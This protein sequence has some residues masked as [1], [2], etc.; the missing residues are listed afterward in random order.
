MPRISAPTLVEHRQRQRAAL[1]DA[2]EDIVVE[3]GSTNVTVSAVA[4]RAGLARSS[5]YEYF[6]SP[7]ALLAA[8]VVDR[9][10]RWTVDIARHVASGETPAERIEIFVRASLDLTSKGAH[11]LGR[12]V[13]I[14]DMPPECSDAL[15]DMHRGM[16]APL[17]LALAD[18]GIPDADRAA[19]L[20][21]GVIQAAT[22]RIEQGAP[23]RRETDA[24]VTF[25]MQ[26]LELN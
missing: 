19:D 25:V 6:G 18:A 14:S 13:R 20:V 8:A 4:V 9:M 15:V 5:V 1:L 26:A 10:E 24:A 7:S 22:N 17:A 21:L 3:T 11:R 16:T 12:V 23:R 2:V